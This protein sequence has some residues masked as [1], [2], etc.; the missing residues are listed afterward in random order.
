MAVPLQFVFYGEL[1]LFQS[2]AV[3]GSQKCVNLG[4]IY[5]SL[6]EPSLNHQPTSAVYDFNKEPWR[7]ASQNR[8][9]VSTFKIANANS[10]ILQYLKAFYWERFLEPFLKLM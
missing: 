5:P 6:L 3:R 1:H 8:F 7:V 2:A 9:S 10:L 4:E